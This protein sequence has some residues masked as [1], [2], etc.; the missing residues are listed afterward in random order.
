MDLMPTILELCDIEPAH[1]IEGV[2]VVPLIR[3]HELDLP[4]AFVVETQYR[5]SDKMGV[6]TPRWTYF[7]NR[8]GH[9]GLGRRELHLFGVMENGP[10]TDQMEQNKE[11]AA[12]LSAYLE[13]W[14]REHPRT[15]ATL[16]DKE[17]APAEIEQ[18]R[19]LG[20]IQ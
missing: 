11:A 3:G 18:L 15:P 6:Y 10:R 16:T 5:W 17:L 19:A 7:E 12:R 14:E 1:N 20:Y 4:E 8:D 9:P 13:S 2:S